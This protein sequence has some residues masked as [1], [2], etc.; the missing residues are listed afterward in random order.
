MTATNNHLDWSI[1]ALSLGGII[2]GS[3]LESKETLIFGEK[4]VLETNAI[5]H[6]V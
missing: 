6:R 3:P 1:S 5:I 2:L 4:S